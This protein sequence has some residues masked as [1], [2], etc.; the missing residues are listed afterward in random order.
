MSLNKEKVMV[1]GEVFV[2]GFALQ[3]QDE[4]AIGTSAIVGLAQGL[5]YK[6][7]VKAGAQGFA[8]AMVVQGLL[9]G[10]VN[11]VNAYKDIKNH[12][13]AFMDGNT[14]YTYSV[15]EKN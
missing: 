5:K 13:N 14:L 6:G 9:C 10:I 3:L 4:N 12:D 1:L 2:K 11:T 8:S 7:S 15:K